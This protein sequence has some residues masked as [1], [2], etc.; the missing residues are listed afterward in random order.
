MQLDPRIFD[1]LEVSKDVNEVMDVV[2]NIIDNNA[3]INIPKFV[4]V[5]LVRDILKNKQLLP[6]RVEVNITPLRNFSSEIRS[7]IAQSKYSEL[8]KDRIKQA[9]SLFKSHVNFRGVVPIASLDKVSDKFFSKVCGLVLEKYFKKNHVVFNIED[10]T[11]VIEV[12]VPYDVYYKYGEV[13]LDECV[14][15]EVQKEKEGVLCKRFFHIDVGD[16]VKNTCESD[17][18]VA[19]LSNL[20][21]GS[22]KFDI[23]SWAR[24][25]SWING[26]F[27]DKDVI[28][29]LELLVIVGDLIDVEDSSLTREEAYEKAAHLLSELPPRMKI[30]IIPGDKDASSFYLPQIPIMR[31]LSKPLYNLKNVQMEG[32]PFYF[33][34][35]GVKILL[36]HGQSLDGVSKQ[37]RNNTSSAGL[38]SML[39]RARHLAPTVSYSWFELLSS[40]DTLFI[41]DVPN[42]FVCGHL[43]QKDIGYYKG[44]LLVSLPSWTNDQDTIGGRCAVVNLRTF[45]VLWR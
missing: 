29:S 25:V 35:N 10:L 4:G 36:F 43:S 12:I 13:L 27:G 23:E 5:D 3:S 26:N 7:D 44:I 2:M 39:L 32:N 17:I 30:L 41:N 9:N 8:L 40:N 34:I 38:M 6:R 20:N 33:S 31:A 15:F 24:F 42:I 28:D 21:V 16:L 37:I 18:H 22:K 1:L 14:L 45:E 19:F 11:G